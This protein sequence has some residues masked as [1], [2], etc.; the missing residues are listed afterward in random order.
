M[1]ANKGSF[2][3]QWCVQ[4]QNTSPLMNIFIASFYYILS[5]AETVCS[6][7]SFFF[8]YHEC[9]LDN[10]ICRSKSKIK[11]ITAMANANVN[12]YINKVTSQVFFFWTCITRNKWNEK[13]D[14]SDKHYS[15]SAQRCFTYSYVFAS[16]PWYIIGTVLS[17]NSGFFHLPCCKNVHEWFEEHG[18]E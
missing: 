11:R 13:K 8:F 6:A 5:M 2:V 14:Y 12:S 3:I 10:C 17:H 7:E 15:H 18:Q 9:Y 1:W 16:L 4:G